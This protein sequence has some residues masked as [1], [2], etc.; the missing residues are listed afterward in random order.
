MPKL[1]QR[2][3]IQFIIPLILLLGIIGVVYLV[4]KGPLKIFPKASV[5][6]PL[7]PT[8]AF[9]LS[10]N[11]SQYAVGEEVAVAIQVRSDIAATN[12]YAAKISYDPQV[13][14][15]GR[16]DVTSPFIKNWVEQYWGD[17]GKISLVGGVPTPGFQTNVE[18]KAT[19]ATLVFVALKPGS[20]TISFDADS[21]IY[22]NADNTNILVGKESVTLILSTGVS[23][24][25]VPTPTPYVCSACDADINQDGPVTILDFSILSTCFNKKST[26]TNKGVSCNRADINKDGVVTILDF[27]CLADKFNKLCSQ[28]VRET[29]PD[30]PMDQA[31][32]RSL[33]AQLESVT[34]TPVA[35]PKPGTGDGNNDGK[36]NLVDLS[37]LLSDFNKTAGFRKGVDLNGDGKINTFD[38]S[39]MRNLLIEKKVIKG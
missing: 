36:I 8:T 28:G 27:S 24:P 10:P 37:V 35:T 14:Q 12:L 15:L 33:Q 39:L 20:T 18:D 16:V 17:P 29:G 22:S 6:A 32:R 25:V 9:V 13:L 26:D 7:T 3:A 2:G 38:F 11:K 21:A 19:M 4:T 31:T 1:S 34:L 23:P 30:A 5:S